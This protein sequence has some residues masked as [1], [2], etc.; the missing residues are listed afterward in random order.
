MPPPPRMNPREFAVHVVRVLRGAGHEAL[1]A[2]GCV[3]DELLKLVPKDYDV[4]T[5][6]RPEEVQALF[7]RTVAVGAAFGVVEVLG[8]GRLNIQVATFRS[9]GAYIDGRHPESVVYSTAEEDAQRRDFTIN[10]MFFDPLGGRLIDYV[11]GQADLQA[12]LLRAIG[13]PAER[14]RE[15]RLRILRG[16]RLAARFGLE[17][18]PGTAAAMRR[19][20]PILHDG[21]SAE[22]VAE[23]LRKILVDPNRARGMRM[24]MD[25]GL[26][27][28]VMPDLVPMVGLPYGLPRADGPALPPPGRPGDAETDL[29][30][31]VL[32]VLDLLGDAP[33]FP[34]AMA[35]LLHDVGKPRTVGRTPDRYTFYGHEHVGRRLA[36][37][38]AERLKLSNDERARIEWLVEK[39]QVLSESRRMRPA[40]LKTLLVH[41]GIE[42]LFTLHR[43]D[44]VASGRD[45]D[46]VDYAVKLRADW[47]ASGELAPPPLLTGNDL[48][49]MGLP[50][51]P[52]FKRLLDKVREAQ[53]DGVLRTRDE[54]VAMVRRLLAEGDEQTDTH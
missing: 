13:D 34:L 40:K 1:W 8:R 31:H 19:M 39:H 12:K 36:A 29:W 18:E 5:S 11:G 42:E 52:V 25:M 20:A 28:V 24:F 17:I 37:E 2:G 35:A 47:D 16:V 15:D 53:L 7:D 9:D 49:E 44:A 41:K 23:E 46:H 50:Q 30:E 21:V 3:R 38:I 10:G 27:A 43:A 51:G 48:L 4:A 33:S 22:R 14:F 26:A 54:A 45:C 6:A 32:R